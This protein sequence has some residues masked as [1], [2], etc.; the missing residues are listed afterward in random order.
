LQQPSYSNQ[1]ALAL[2]S[3]QGDADRRWL[4]PVQEGQA[5]PNLS[6]LCPWFT[7]SEGNRPENRMPE[8]T[9]AGECFL[10]PGFSGIWIFCFLCLDDKT[11]RLQ[12]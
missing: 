9:L 10:E 6:S 12:N 1:A 3:E 8:H 11:I 7:A 5:R 2:G 4:C